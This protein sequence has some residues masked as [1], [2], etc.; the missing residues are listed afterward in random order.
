MDQEGQIVPLE[1]KDGIESHQVQTGGSNINS[2]G[3][4]G[5]RQVLSSLFE[6]VFCGENELTNLLPDCRIIAGMAGAGLPQNQQAIISLIEERGVSQHRISVM[7]DAEMALRLID[8]EGGDPQSPA[9]ALFA[10]EKKEMKPRYRVGGLGRI[11]GD[12]GSGYQI[13]LQALKAAIAEEYGWGAATRLTPALKQLFQVSELK[14]LIPKI[15]LGEIPPSKI[16]SRAP[17]VF[18]HASKQDEMANEIIDKAA[19][20]LN[21]LLASMVNLSHL[22]NCEVHLWGGIFKNAY[23]ETF[24]QKVR[25]GLPENL[26]LINQSQNNPA[27]LFATQEFFKH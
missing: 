2:I 23:S 3:T 16:A 24:I 17:L 4:E 21:D 26:K 11:L 19:Q 5:I 1:I 18:Y 7:S 8:G 10:W 14:T 20:D 9:Q 15:N 12:E 22:N 13:G 25:E 6:G 27:V